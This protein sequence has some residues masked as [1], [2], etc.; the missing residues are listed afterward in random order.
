MF[1]NLIKTLFVFSLYKKKKL[2]ENLQ[3]YY[4]L[5][6]KS[7]IFHLQ[8][9]YFPGALSY[10][11]LGTLI[12]KSG[13]EYAYLHE[14]FGPFHKTLGPIPAF[15][16]AWTSVLILKPALFG[17]VSMSFALYTTEPFFEC[18][19]PDVLVK[20]VSIVCLCKLKFYS[21]IYSVPW[22]KIKVKDVSTYHFPTGQR[23]LP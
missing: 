12:T 21:D 9:F 10:A 3:R 1:S 16:F 22:R 5:D 23:I 14:A 13:A 7:K 6:L 18:G 8:F 2:K 15:L 4:I 11:E 20:I 19:P 17:V